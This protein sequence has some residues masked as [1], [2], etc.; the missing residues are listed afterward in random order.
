MNKHNVCDGVFINEYLL[1]INA[2]DLWMHDF[3]WWWIIG[4]VLHNANMMPWYVYLD[5]DNLWRCGLYANF[6]EWCWCFCCVVLLSSHIHC[7]G[8]DGLLCQATMGFMPSVPNYGQSDGYHMHNIVVS[9]GV[10]YVYVW[11]VWR[12]VLIDGRCWI[13]M[14]YDALFGDDLYD[15]HEMNMT[16]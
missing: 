10:S 3:W 8:N 4:D 9:H 6:D 15:E 13:A 2:S 14:I 12:W 11:V 5:A 1:L 7:I 16:W